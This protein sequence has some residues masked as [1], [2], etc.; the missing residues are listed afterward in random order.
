[1]IEE[2]FVRIKGFEQEYMISNYGRVVRLFKNG[3]IK[4]KKQLKN[5]NGYYRVDL[6]KNNKRFKM[7]VH[8]LVALHFIDNPEDLS[9]VHHEDEDKKNNYFLNLKWCTH[10]QNIEWYHHG[11][12]DMEATG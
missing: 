4:E 11:S 1:M 3:N 6:W 7:R 9:D 5:H 12:T 2:K 8:R 10:D